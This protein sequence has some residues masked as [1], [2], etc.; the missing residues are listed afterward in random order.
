MYTLIALL[1]FSTAASALDSSHQSIINAMKDAGLSPS[2]I[3]AISKIGTEHEEAL[4]ALQG[5]LANPADAVKSLN[6]AIQKFLSTASKSDQKAYKVFEEKMASN[7]GDFFAKDMKKA[8]ISQA[9]IDGVLKIEKK[10]EAALKATRGDLVGL[11]AAFD[12]LKS[13]VKHYISGTS[14][15][16]QAAWENYEKNMK[17]S[18]GTKAT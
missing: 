1:A 6:S 9:T 10:H 11:K 17:S 5:Q 13:E 16:D 4:Q 7:Y 14:A 15:A 3:Q 18:F 2:A 8:G 12:A